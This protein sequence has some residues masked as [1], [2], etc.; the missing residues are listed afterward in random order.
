MELWFY[1]PAGVFQ[2]ERQLNIPPLLDIVQRLKGIATVLGS[3]RIYIVATQ[4]IPRP[5][6][7]SSQRFVKVAER[8]ASSVTITQV[9][10]SGNV[11]GVNRRSG[12]ILD[13]VVDCMDTAL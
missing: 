2:L 1:L 3:L 13:E 12:W 7:I 9:Q 8:Q 4:N 10:G 11:V 6:S 5:D